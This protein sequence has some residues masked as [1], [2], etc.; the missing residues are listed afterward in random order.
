MKTINI[1]NIDLEK[2]GPE[3][4][5]YENQWIAISSDNA[6]VGSGATYGEAVDSVGERE[7]VILLKVPPLDVS[8]A[9]QA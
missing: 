2:L 5:K 3:I 6:I 1:E 9:P 7:D 4:Q 8:F